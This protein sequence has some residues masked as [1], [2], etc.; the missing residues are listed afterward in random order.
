MEYISV[1]T[2]NILA[3]KYKSA[4]YVAFI[5]AVFVLL[6]VLA[7]KIIPVQETSL[8]IGNWERMIWGAVIALGILVVFLRRVLTS[9]SMLNKFKSNGSGE[10]ISMLFASTI[11]SIFIAELI[12][13]AGLFLY[14]ITANNN[15]SWRFGVIAIIIIIYSIPRRNEWEK[16]VA[17]FEK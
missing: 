10:I 8:D 9:K 6:L 5:G 1:E 7:G 17:S 14:K 13:V 12:G 11:I 3:R 2:Q 16:I 15:Y 4:I